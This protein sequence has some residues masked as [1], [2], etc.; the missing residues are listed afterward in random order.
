MLCVGLRTGGSPGLE[1]SGFCGSLVSLPEAPLASFGG[2]IIGGEQWM[3][4]L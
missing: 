2:I 3:E 1:H 4:S